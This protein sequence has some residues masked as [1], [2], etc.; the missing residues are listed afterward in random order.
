MRTGVIKKAFMTASLGLA[1]FFSGPALAA[2]GIVLL[3]CV[4]DLEVSDFRVV[5][6]Y[7]TKGAKGLPSIKV[8]DLCRPAHSALKEADCSTMDLM[9]PRAWKA[10]RE[11][12]PP[13]SKS[14]G[15]LG[16]CGVP[17]PQ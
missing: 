8:G 9:S 10:L 14:I 5:R 1:L 6:I 7:I 3:S 4:I 13:Y 11:A 2:S 12:K 16:F 17:L 15:I